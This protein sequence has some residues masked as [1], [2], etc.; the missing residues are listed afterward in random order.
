MAAAEPPVPAAA[1]AG[2]PRPAVAGARAK[3][4]LGKNQERRIRSGHPWVFSNEIE[5]IEGVPEPG[6][7]VLV[8]DHRGGTVGVGLYNPHS[9]IAVRLFARLDQSPANSLREIVARQKTLL[10]VG[11]NFPPTR[12]VAS[13]TIGQLPLAP[14]KSH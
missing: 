10:V 4:I 7:E 1:P 12:E 5:S 3:L 6:G 8:Q 2:R 9:L 11:L 14:G 13:I